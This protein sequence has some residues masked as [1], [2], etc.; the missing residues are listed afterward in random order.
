MALAIAGCNPIKG[1]PGAD[2]ENKL[3]SDTTKF[4]HVP[5]D[6]VQMY[7]NRAKYKCMEVPEGS[8]L[9]WL[10]D[11]D[12]QERSLWVKHFQNSE[13]TLGQ[14]ITSVYDLRDAHW[15]FSKPQHPAAL[16]DG[17]RPEIKR[18]RGADQHQYQQGAQGGATLL[19][20][21]DKKITGK[22]DTKGKGDGKPLPY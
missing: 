1:A 18:R 2:E 8:R 3:G 12:T 4:V 6:V 11:K 5:L 20:I 16:A 17:E 14:V 7:W 9:A 10:R 13:R 15:E 21:K 19:A 22:G